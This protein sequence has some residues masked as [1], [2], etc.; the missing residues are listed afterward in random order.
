[1]DLFMLNVLLHCF[2]SKLLENGLD[3]NNKYFG[4]LESLIDFLVINA[5]Y[6]R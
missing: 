5:D 6:F 1:M 3:I 4:T 2:R